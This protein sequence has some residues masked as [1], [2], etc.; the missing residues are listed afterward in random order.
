MRNYLKE[1]RKYLKIKD[2]YHDDSNFEENR[3]S[4]SKQ[5]Q[6]IENGFVQYI[7]RSSAYGVK[8]QI[9]TIKKRG[10][11]Y[12]LEVRGSDDVTMGTA[13]FDENESGWQM[14]YIKQYPNVEQWSGHYMRIIDSGF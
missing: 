2:S 7:E 12:L 5:K 11:N 8:S 3:Q 6:E 1:I 14:V 13:Q 9:I 4:Q 10:V